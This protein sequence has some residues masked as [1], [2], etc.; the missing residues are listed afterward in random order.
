MKLLL[1][2]VKI[3]DKNSPFNGQNKDILIEDGIIKK[4]D[5]T[6]S[7]SNC[8]KVIEEDKLNVSAG[9]IDFRTNLQD[10][11]L[12]FKEDIESGLNA[13]A[14]GGFTAICATSTTTPSCNS[15]TNVNYLISQSKNHLVDLLPIGNLSD[16]LNGK[17]MSEMYD[18]HTSG[19]V[20]FSDNKNS[21]Q[22][23]GLMSR[24][25]LYAKGFDGLVMNFPSDKNLTNGGLV[26]ESA[27]TN[28]IGLKG[29]PSL[30]EE[31][32]VI[33]DIYLADYHNSRVHIGPISC[34]KSVE[35]IKKAKE[36]GIDVSCEVAVH[37]LLFT[38]EDVITFDSN[39]KV[40]PPYRSKSDRTALIN[41]VIDGTIDIISTDHTP[42]DTE[43]KVLEF[44]HANDGIIGLQTFFSILNELF[45]EIMPLDELIQKISVNP[46][47]LLK[48]E[49]PIIKEGFEAN[50]TLFSCE[51]EW[52]FD[53]ASNASKSNNSPFIGHTLKGK[54][55]GVINKTKTEFYF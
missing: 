26:N 16:N 25:I 29:N 3:I 42:E 55:L 9:W 23:A 34:A 37:N 13:A 28:R 52:T 19:A 14:K 22:D 54:S 39:Y 18:M 49:I 41:G 24:A 21:I 48:I 38:D 45:G 33:R 5:E 8:Y 15:K 2:N 47:S 1:K 50:L 51:K 7:E 43:C 40:N 31:A 32:M 6:I 11:G 27:L 46:R 4:I 20:A 12:E 53:T 44:E 36:D 30:S 17:D 10:P 35:L